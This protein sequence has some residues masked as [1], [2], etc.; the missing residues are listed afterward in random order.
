MNKEQIR[1]HAQNQT[2]RYSK[3]V[4]DIAICLILLGMHD[5]F[6]YKCVLL[7]IQTLLMVIIVCIFMAI[8]IK[9][10]R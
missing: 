2:E 3:I 7:T 1:K 9:S 6:A 10:S 5:F 4:G 8:H